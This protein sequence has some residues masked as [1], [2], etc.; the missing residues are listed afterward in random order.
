MAKFK[1]RPRPSF[2]HKQK[3]FCALLL[4][5]FAA[6]SFFAFFF[7]CGSIYGKKEGGSVN[8]RQS[9]FPPP[10][11]SSLLPCQQN[12]F[13]PSPLFPQNTLFPP[14][15]P[16]PPPKVGHLRCLSPSLLRR[17][18]QISPGEGGENK[19]PTSPPTQFPR[20]HH[21]PPP[22]QKKSGGGK[23]FFLLK[24]ESGGGGPIFH[25]FVCGKSPVLW[26]GN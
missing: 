12:I 9:P 24:M 5:K 23:L 4:L 11:F 17:A 3:L 16:P 18:P 2:P 21:F 19:C 26:S 14:P 25:Q 15:P 8:C 1:V 7:F 13:P 20:N 22:P 6:F 10:P